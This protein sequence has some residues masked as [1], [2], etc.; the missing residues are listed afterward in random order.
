MQYTVDA[1]C[2]IGSETAGADCEISAAAGADDVGI[3][4]HHHIFGVGLAEYL[5]GSSHVVEVR[6]AVEQDLRVLPAEAEFLHARTDLRR[7]AF[8]IGVDQD[9][10]SRCRNEVGGEI[11]TADVVEVV[12]DLER[13]Q[14]RCPVRIDLATE[15]RSEEKQEADRED[16][17]HGL[18]QS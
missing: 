17:S 8:Q 6:L 4:V 15:R 13:R 7:R 11:A 12:G 5:R 10:P 3:P 18:F 2:G 9:V 1:R 14:R 16:S